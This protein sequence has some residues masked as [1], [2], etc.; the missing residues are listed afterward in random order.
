MDFDL[1]TQRLQKNFAAAIELARER[2]HVQLYPLHLLSAIFDDREGIARQLVLKLNWSMSSIKRTLESNLSKLPAQSPPPSNY[3]FSHGM[4]EVWTKARA[5]QKKQGDSHVSVDTMLLALLELKD[6]VV[7]LN[8]AGVLK[9]ALVQAITDMRGS[10]RV[11]SDNP[12]ANYE[13]LSKY[14]QNLVEL[15]IQGKLDPVIGRDDEIRRVIRVLARRTKNNPVLIGPPGVGKTAIAEGLAQRIARGDVPESLHCQLFSLD[16]GALIAGAKYRGEFEERLKSVLKE[17]QEA[18]GKIILFIDEM[19]LILGAGKTDGAMDAANLLK[20][21]L[22]RGELRCIGATTLEEYRKY[23]EKDA[24]FERRFQPVYVGEPSVVDTVSILRGLKERY[25]THHGVRIADGALVLAAQLAHRYITNRFLPDKAIDLVDEACAHTRVALDSQPEIMD[26]LSRRKLQ[27]EVEATALEREKDAASQ[28]RLVKVREEMSRIEEE[29]LPLRVRYEREKSRITEVQE[30]NKK[31]DSLRVKLEEANRRY[32]LALAADIKYGAIPDLEKR[33]QELTE[34]KAHADESM[35]DAESEA[36][37]TEEVGPDQI[38]DVVARWTGIPVTRLSQSQSDRLLGLADR[39]KRRVV[40]QDAAVTAVAEAIIRSRS[41]LSRSNQPIGSF[42]F[43]GPTGVGKTELAKALAFELFDDEKHI[44]CIDMSEYME[45]HSVSRLIGAPPG[46]VGYE[47]GGQLSE[48]IRRRPYNV[49]LFDEVEK[50]HGDV[51]NVLLQVLDDGRLTDGQGR[52][53]DFSNT[54]IILTSNVGAELMQLPDGS[55]GLQLDKTVREGVMAMVRSH[56]RPEFLNRLDDIVIFNPL[57]QDHLAKIV[58]LQMS[59]IG[60]L[61]ESREITIKLDDTAVQ[62]ILKEAYNPAYG[63]R[64]LRRYMEKAIV[65]Q[66]SMM[67]LSPTSPLKNGS[68]VT[69]YDAAKCPSS[70]L[71]AGLLAYEVDSTAPMVE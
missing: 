16:M 63:A 49:V 25:E 52:T 11:T 18:N 34:S 8:E 10:S 43:L 15:A 5:L 51:L 30:L 28:Q 22:A 21:L 37:L 9:P 2:S 33:L 62:A 39:L 60:K 1:L 23:V 29:L 59:E 7:M 40:G 19:H 36:L 61:L 3:S 55:G 50:A 17:V 38:T 70:A 27:L 65:T 46:Y 41:G 12:E 69:V 24:A 53:I 47:E 48:A 32:D 35:S 56:F 6:L 58:R 54:V 64:P 13:S 4:T 68:A 66:L 26:A 45:K 20:P 31:L 44:V 57:T 67:L 14:A 42:L 71:K